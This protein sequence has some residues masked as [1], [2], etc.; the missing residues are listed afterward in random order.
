ML[1]WSEHFEDLPSDDEAE[2]IVTKPDLIVLPPEP[3]FPP[4]QEQDTSDEKSTSP[5]KGPGK[6][7]EKDKRHRPHKPRKLPLMLVQ[8]KAVVASAVLVLGVAMAVYGT[9]GFRG[10]AGYGSGFEF[11]GGG[12]A[13]SQREW[14]AL[15]R[16]VGALVFGAGERLV[17]SMWR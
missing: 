7:K 3:E 10:D 8:R 13:R 5:S 9:G 12:L 1:T 17:E 2:L 15:G 14:K 16:F 4:D 11:G 6:G